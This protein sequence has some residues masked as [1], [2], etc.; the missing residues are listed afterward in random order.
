MPLLPWIG[1]LLGAA[2]AGLGVWTALQEPRRTVKARLRAVVEGVAALPTTT[3]DRSRGRMTLRRPLRDRR[4]LPRSGPPPSP[5]A[6][7]QARLLER[8]GVPL[9]PAEY[10]GLRAG[11]A[12]LGALLG[13]A[14]GGPVAAGVL[15]VVGLMAP[16]VWVRRR[17]QSRMRQVEGQLA[18]A[19]V[20]MASGLHAGYSLP[21]ALASASRETPEPLGHYLAEV[22]RRAGVGAPIEETLAEIAARL[23]SADLDMVATAIAVERKVGG[24]LAEILDSMAVTLRE[25]M[26]LRMRLRAM[27]SQNRLSATILTLLPVGVGALLALT[28][29]SF[30]S[31]LWTTTPGL[32]ILAAI[33]VLDTMGALWIRRVTRLDV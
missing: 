22:H 13:W 19:L 9:R 25:R 6:L 3:T 28:A 1:F 4:R 18:D 15:V 20:L 12:A 8:A 24:S 11:S 29:R 27:T 16:A 26:Q 32:G 33:V 2:L 30:I 23:E 17:A 14:M 21:Q 10:V 31:I 5:R 7:A